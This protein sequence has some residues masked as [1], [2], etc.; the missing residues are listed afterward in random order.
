M[1]ERPGLRQETESCHPT[2]PAQGLGSVS[3]RSSARARPYSALA[4]LSG[5][6]HSGP[7]T[8]RP[9]AERA[10]A[11]S[12]AV[13][14]TPGGPTPHPWAASSRSA[15]PASCTTG[16]HRPRASTAPRPP[17]AASCRIRPICSA[18]SGETRCTPTSDELRSNRGATGLR[19]G[20]SV[21]TDCHGRGRHA[22]AR[23]PHSAVADDQ[24]RAAD[25]RT[26]RRHPR[27][28]VE[29][30][31]LLARPGGLYQLRPHMRAACLDGHA[32]A[33]AGR[34]QREHLRRPQA[35][36]QHDVVRRRVVEAHAL[37][38]APPRPCR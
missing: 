11:V 33:R 3:V 1:A 17:A 6:A 12:Q 23:R 10:G 38:A 15:G 29:R 18:S 14:E 31:A 36:D 34:A 9:H 5:R 24:Y 22:P 13:V 25:R 35:A 26:H 19:Y 30:D 7:N 2:Q 16:S 4:V 20:S 27:H 32:R 37:A 28:V 8:P 21:S